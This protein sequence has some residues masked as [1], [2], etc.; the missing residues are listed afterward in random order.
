[1][2]HSALIGQPPL[3][4]GKDYWIVQAIL[5]TEGL[6]G[7]MPVEGGAIIPPARPAD[8]HFETQGPAIIAGS[9]I[10]IVCMATITGLRL[11]LR[12]T[13][14]G[15]HWGVDDWIMIPSIVSYR[16]CHDHTRVS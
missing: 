9:V 1:M 11:W 13:H 14:N 7:K 8:Y 2:V 3:D 5:I 6:L 12:Y 16:S 10:S 15:L 4:N